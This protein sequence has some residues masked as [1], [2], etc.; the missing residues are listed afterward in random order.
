MV[1]LMVPP[2]RATALLACVAMVPRPRFVR[3]APAVVAL[4]LILIHYKIN[5]FKN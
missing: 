5:L 3:A 2:V 1:P 4:V